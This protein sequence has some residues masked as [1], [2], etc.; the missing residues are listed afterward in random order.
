M[1]VS[2]ERERRGEEGEKK[3]PKRGITI[4]SWWVFDSSQSG[5]DR[6]KEEEK[7][8]RTLLVMTSDWY[9][10]TGSRGGTTW[11]EEKNGRGRGRRKERSSVR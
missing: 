11:Q 6:K 1:W 4:D 9:Q 7:R 8:R 2:N 5:G 3:D 10:V